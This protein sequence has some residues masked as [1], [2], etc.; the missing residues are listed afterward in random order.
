MIKKTELARRQTTAQVQHSDKFNLCLVASA[1]L[2]CSNAQETIGDQIR[3]HRRSHRTTSK[4]VEW[5]LSIAGL[6][7]PRQLEESFYWTIL[8][9][10]A[11][12]CTR[13]HGPGPAQVMS[14]KK[15]DGR[16]HRMVVLTD[17]FL[18]RKHD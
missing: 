11:N 15:T 8:F 12:G 3:P 5:Q 4:L 9:G 6:A 1:P 17:T 14:A 18:G 10:P 7:T 13:V 16:R 2:H